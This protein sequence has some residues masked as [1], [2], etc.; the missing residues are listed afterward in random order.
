[1][2]E[3]A[4]GTAW[5]RE[6]IPGAN[7]QPTRSVKC[8]LGENPPRVIEGY[9]TWNVIERPRRKSLTEW[10]GVKPLKIELQL[11]ID[12]FDKNDGLACERDMRQLELMA[13]A[14][15]K[16]K[17]EAPPTPIRWDA[18]AMHDD[19]EAGHLKWVI[20]TLQWDHFMWNKE[21]PNIVR[22]NCTVTL[23][24]YV[25]DQFITEGGAAKNRKKKP[26]KKTNATHHKNTYRVTLADT[27]KQGL[28]TIAQKK[29]GDPKKWRKIANAQKHKIRDPMN[30]KVDQVLVI[31]K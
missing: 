17:R 11:V 14:S 30:I 28:R 24:E 10:Q 19:R 2:G 18:N 26:R 8:L 1:V 7:K 13:G 16:G 5:L 4:S 20:E 12:Y 29:Y 3:V 25:E 27:N 9:A 21:G 6:Y 22:A 23:M 15:E 31:P